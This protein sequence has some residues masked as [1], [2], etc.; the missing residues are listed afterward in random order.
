MNQL[1]WRKRSTAWLKSIRVVWPSTD[2]GG[3]CSKWQSQQSWWPGQSWSP[4][5]SHG[6]RLCPPGRAPCRHTV[7]GAA[8]RLCR[9]MRYPPWCCPSCCRRACNQFGK[10]DWKSQ[11]DLHKKRLSASVNSFLYPRITPG[12]GRAF[13]QVCLS[14]LLTKHRQVTA[15][16]GVYSPRGLAFPQKLAISKK[17]MNKFFS[18]KSALSA[19]TSTEKK[20]LHWRAPARW[21][22]AAG[23]HQGPLSCRGTWSCRAPFLSGVPVSLSER[24]GIYTSGKYLTP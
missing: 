8:A 17:D 3:C 15:Q 10:Q 18:S 13:S 19:E 2:R 1:L 14:L 4:V 11:R 6:G 21:A 5:K 16:P 9:A 12:I 20:H 22:P 23:A 7:L 24:H